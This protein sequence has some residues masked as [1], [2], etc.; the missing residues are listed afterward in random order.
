MPARNGRRRWVAIAVAGMAEQGR[1]EGEARG[2]EEGEVKG[3]A[4]AA[5]EL[6]EARFGAI[7]PEICDW[8]LTLS[9]EEL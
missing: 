7:D 6:L 9:V 3:L 1:A 4:I 2:R 5:V 8:I